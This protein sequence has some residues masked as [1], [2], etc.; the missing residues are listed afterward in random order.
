MAKLSG[1]LRADWLDRFLLRLGMVLAALIVVGIV[2]TVLGA[3]QDNLIVSVLT[4]IA[5]F[6]VAPF[7]DIF[8]LDD[9]DVAVALNW[10]IGAFVYL[11][12]GVVLADAVGRIRARR[13]T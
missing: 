10:G 4:S 2:L 3:N 7:D 12:L 11:I 1:T 8:E 9:A 5:E 6:L 13:E